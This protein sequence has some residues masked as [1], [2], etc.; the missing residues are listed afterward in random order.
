MTITTHQR[1]ADRPFDGLGDFLAAVRRAA[2]AP[3][4][5]DARLRSQQTTLGETGGFAVP[6][7]PL[8]SLIATI[9]DTSPVLA[10]ITRRV[11]QRGNTYEG[12]LP[13]EPSR[14]DAGRHGGLTATMTVEGFERP[15][16]E[17]KVRRV[18]LGLHKVGVL[19]P[20]T[21]ELVEDGERGW[22]QDVEAI[23]GAE[24]G[25]QMARHVLVGSGVGE[26][27]GLVAAP[28]TQSIAI[29]GTQTI[30]N[31]PDFLFRNA[32]KLLR[33]LRRPHLAVFLMHPDNWHDALT[34]TTAAVANGSAPIVGPARAAGSV[35]TLHQR[36]VFVCEQLPAPGTPGDLVCA[37]LARVL[38]VTKGR[39]T[40]RAVSPHVAFDRDRT[41]FKFTVRMNTQPMLSAPVAPYTG[42]R[43]LSDAT[44]LAA[45]S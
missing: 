7:A 34:A 42:T 30:A 29:E 32:A 16:D 3:E 22:A 10:Q 14:T 28:A 4:S 6:D 23:A 1:E 18:S 26:G 8:D 36:D 2:L 5:I 43:P 12:L 9:L 27:M 13:A 45:R 17:T 35:G 37:D 21:N 38:L 11:V 39:D 44:L 24:I 20:V 40:R 31:T 33:Q 41:L 19:V 15:L 25:W